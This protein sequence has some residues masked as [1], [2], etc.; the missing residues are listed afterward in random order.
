MAAILVAGAIPSGLAAVIK[1]YQGLLVCRFFIGI[2]GSTFVSSQEAIGMIEVDRSTASL[3][4]FPVLPGPRR[5]LARRPSVPQMP[6]PL[7][8]EM[9]EEGEPTSASGRSP[10]LTQSFV[11]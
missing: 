2:L 8:G 6:S 7:D 5:S 1:D 3:D 10:L 4:R 9:L 11:S